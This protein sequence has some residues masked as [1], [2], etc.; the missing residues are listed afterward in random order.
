[1]ALE[2]AWVEEGVLAS[3]LPL[4]VTFHYSCRCSSEDDGLDL[5]RMT[6]NVI[7]Q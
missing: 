6:A 5:A 4:A 3:F 2:M 1:M 7:E